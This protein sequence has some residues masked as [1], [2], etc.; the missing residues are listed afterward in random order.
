[1]ENQ[2]TL[3]TETVEL[4]SKGLLYPE[5]NPLSSGNI[6]IKY[7]TAK[8]ED[9]LTNSSYIQD[10]TVIDKLLKSLVV[11]PINFNDILVGDKNAIMVAARILGYGKEYM[12]Q[13]LDEEYTIDL[14]SLKDKEINEDLYKKDGNNFEFTLPKSQLPITFKLLTQNDEQKIER[15]LKG[16][17]KIHKKAL[18]EL[19]TRLKHIITSIN[20]DSEPKTVRTYIDNAMLAADARALRKYYKEISPDIEMIFEFTDNR[21]EEREA[22]IPIGASFFWPDS[23]I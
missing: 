7:M 9:I 20:G 15:E 19:T 22:S 1:M 13:Y 3:P 11:T 14:T 17:K 12:F 4:P 10:G 23:D 6:E 5:G 16:L 18:P 2:F 8:E 21:G